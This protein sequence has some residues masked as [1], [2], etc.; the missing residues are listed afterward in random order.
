M[1]RVR[2]G[3]A[4]FT[5]FL[6]FIIFNDFKHNGNNGCSK[7]QDLEKLDHEAIL[8]LPPDQV[9]GRREVKVFDENVSSSHTIVFLPGRAP[10]LKWL[11]GQIHGTLTA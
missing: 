9:R 1:D 2:F 11:R 7:K 5:G 3:A 4:F 6:P 8:L 10:L